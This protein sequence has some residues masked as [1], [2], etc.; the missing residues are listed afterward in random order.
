MIQ[1]VRALLRRARFIF[2]GRQEMLD[3]R[4]AESASWTVGAITELACR[5]RRLPEVLVALI[6]QNAREIDALTSE[7]RRLRAEIDAGEQRRGEGAGND[8]RSGH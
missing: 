8:A 4:I 7:V 2:S 1:G 5:Q 6:H 3:T